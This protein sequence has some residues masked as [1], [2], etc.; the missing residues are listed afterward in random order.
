MRRIVTLAISLAVFVFIFAALVNSNR[1]RRFVASEEQAEKGRSGAMQA[2]DFWTRSR[3]YPNKDI[4]A[5]K[6]YRS[7]QLAKAKQKEF[8]NALTAGGTWDP[9]GP[10]N[11]QGRTISVALNPL[12]PNTLYIGSAS[13]GLWRSYSGGVAGDWKQVKL[14]YPALG[15]GAIVIDPTDTNVIYIGTGEVYGY[16][17]VNGGVALRTMRGSY[18][19]GILKTVDGGETWTKSLDWSYNNQRGVEAMKMNP[20]NHN[21]I[22][23]ATTEGLYKSVNAGQSWNVVLGV[24]LGGPELGEDIIINPLDTN[25]IMASFG[26]LNSPLTGIFRTLNGGRYWG[27]VNAIPA[28][29]GKA[30]LEMYGAN[31][32]VVYTSVADSTTGVGS[33]WRTD[34]FGAN[35]VELSDNNNNPIFGDPGSG[36]GWYSH[37]VAVHPD[38]STQVVQACVYRSKSMD[39]G[40]TFFSVAGGYADNHNYAHHPTN[41]D[42]LYVVNDDGVYRSDDFGASFVDVGYGMQTGQFYNGFSCS[43]TDSLLAMG[44]CQDHIPGYRYLGSST[45]NS[46]VTDEVGW[47]AI[48]QSDDHY[49]YAVDRFGEHIYGSNDRGASFYELNGFDGSGAWNSPFVLSPANTNVLYFGDIHLHKS[50]NGGGTWFV[51]NSGAVLDG[52]PALSMAI[53]PTSPDTVYVG[54]AP[55]NTSAH[56]FRTTNGGA[57][58]QDITGTLPDRYPMD[59]AVDPQN[60]RTVYAAMGGFGSGHL[61]KS[62]DAGSNWTDITGSLPDAPTTAVAIDPLHSNIVYA[63]DDLGVYVSTDGGTS[64]SAYSQG[65][66]DAVIAADL[67]ISPSNRALRV[68][69]HGNGV[70]ERKLVGELS[71]NYLDYEA[72]SLDMPVDGAQYELGASITPLRAT[73]ESLSLQS[74]TDS[75]NVRYQIVQ[76][77]NVL[78][79]NT[80]RIAALSPGEA[81]TVTFDG[82]FSPPDTGNYTLQA[83][84]L[85]ADMNAHDDTLKGIITVVFP[86]TIS[87]ALVVKQYSPYSEITGGLPGPAG[88][89]VQSRV[90]LPFSFVYDGYAYDSVQISTNGWMEFGIGT[91][92]SLRGLSTP[93]QIGGD[94]KPGA[95][96]DAERPTK[97]LGP[98]WSDLSTGSS[99][100]ISYQTL[101]TAPNRV[102][103]IQWKNILAY[104]DASSTTTYL[105]FQVRLS[106]S[107]NF[108]DLCYGPLVMGTYP[109]SA[110][111]SIDMKDYIGGN[112]RYYD[113]YSGAVGPMGALASDLNPLADWPGED[114]SYHITTKGITGVRNHETLLPGTF[115]VSQN[116]PNP[117]NPTTRI[118][119]ELPTESKVT[120]TIFDLQGREVATLVN[121]VQEAGVKSVDWNSAN[122]NAGSVASGVYFYRVVATSIAEPSKS[123]T[124]VRKMLLLR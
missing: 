15:I 89:D 29:T 24:D 87:S 60:S 116:Y 51:T 36:Q 101:G 21:T 124:Q 65:L 37:F 80:K 6:Y 22:W 46:S 99:G 123:F 49:A 88:D 113:I 102:F 106:E 43:K 84:S 32:N 121:A 78:Y 50:T 64:W 59:L 61:F 97:A 75:F 38:D 30:R 108:I 23:A 73:F 13:G 44:Q 114:S 42:I 14:G 115:H 11:L 69:T 62:I 47:T 107:S 25:K 85:F 31:P 63:G 120:L 7:Y 48:N 100:Q 33:L 122:V 58:W 26:D 72:L 53:S 4:P 39:G 10:M 90:G 54:M 117:F 41:P 83:I 5:D 2:L 66:P 17:A 56:V 91:P 110:G 18:G 98:W 103:V 109:P 45:W 76:G 55:V 34:D 1:Y 111:A 8:T 119:Y 82:S 77:S 52:N 70:W 95:R 104:Y 74:P 92:G 93:G 9:I 40:R 118:A 27:K 81:K 16:Q 68:A 71:S 79:S 3:A 112:Y 67:V 94:F 96:A 86:P 35:W 19:I 12:N 20:L 28:F 57:S 105:N